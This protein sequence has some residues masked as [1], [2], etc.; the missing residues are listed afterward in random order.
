LLDEIR[1]DE[2]DSSQTLSSADLE[3]VTGGLRGIRLSHTRTATP[4]CRPRHDAA[5]K[6]PDSPVPKRVRLTHRRRHANAV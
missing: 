6:Q 3:A 1:A 2:K 5:G 4:A